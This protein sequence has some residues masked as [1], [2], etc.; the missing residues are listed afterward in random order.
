MKH[1]YFVKE[2][3]YRENQGTSIDYSF[4]GTLK[5]AKEHLNAD[6]AANIPFAEHLIKDTKFDIRN[7]SDVTENGYDEHV[8]YSY[9]Q[10]YDEGP[11]LL[12]VVETGAEIVR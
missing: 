3:I 11:Y 1:V 10:S 12:H 7:I 4:F 9:W 6:R 8:H 5:R 2:T